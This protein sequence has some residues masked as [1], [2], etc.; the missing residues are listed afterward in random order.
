MYMFYRSLS[1]QIKHEL[2]GQMAVSLLHS[3]DYA[4]ETAGK[5][6]TRVSSMSARADIAGES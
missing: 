2:K 6:Q 3:G 5:S 1:C 4:G